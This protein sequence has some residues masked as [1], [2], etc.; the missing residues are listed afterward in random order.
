MN[1][2][3]VMD[4]LS[5]CGLG[6]LIIDKNK[7]ILA[8]NETGDRLLHSDGSLTGQP[9]PE[10]AYPLCDPKNKN[11]Y[12]KIAFGDY[13]TALPSPPADGL[14]LGSTLLVF[15]DASAEVQN[16]MLSEIVNHIKETIVVCDDESKLCFFNDPAVKMDAL[17]AENVIGKR[18]TDVYQMKND[19]DGCL[20]PETIK[21]KHPFL[22]ERHQYTTRCGKDVNAVAN[23]YPVIK[24]GQVLG[25]FNV[26]EDWSTISDLNKQ[27]IDLQEKIV[28]NSTTDKPVKK[29]ALNAKYTFNDIIYSSSAMDRIIHQCDQVAKTDFPVMIYGETGTGK[30]LFAQSIHNAS[31]RA[32]GPFLAINCAALPESLLE[33]LLFGSV[34]GAYTGAE[35]RPGLFEQANH[36][37][38]LL[39][40][41][42][43]MDITLQAKLLRVLQDSMIRR[44][45]SSSEIK[46]DVRVLSCINVPPTQAIREKKLRQDLF[47]RLGVINI[48]IPPLR[49]RKEDITL[50]SKHFIMACNR[51]LLK[52]VR[53]IA[54]E[55]QAVFNSYHWPGNV[56]ELQHAIE[57]AMIILPDDAEDITLDYLPRNPNFLP[58]RK[59][60]SDPAANILLRTP[61]CNEST[62][63]SL[64]SKLKNMERNTL[65]EILAQNNGNISKSA[66]Q[67][68]MSRQ[69]LQY[70]IKRFQIDID[71]F[72][73]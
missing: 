36:G 65:C 26:V 2:K 37:T 47:Y 44:V 8:I 16:T 63:Q 25:A 48:D 15:K 6:V 72:R 68:Q 57:H 38:L 53:N 29:S 56:R 1:D 11:K 62:D 24:N 52:N 27:I 22:N 9:L 70:R 42:N 5:Q 46:V 64:N 61:E 35:N 39:D 7:T 12:I 59:D 28:E 19:Q 4:V 51:K 58:E 71:A 10:V 66:K 33:S 3:Q 14:P 41:I 18:V 13:V 40:E 55:T 67:L 34:K 45:G 31:L 60:T 21:A 54:L 30:E 23:S 32:N 17:V 69:N 73:K 20:L 50:L 43:S 49:K